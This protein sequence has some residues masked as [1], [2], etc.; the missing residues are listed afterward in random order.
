MCLAL[1]SWCSVVQV[2]ASTPEAAQGFWTIF[3]TRRA[4][5]DEGGFRSAA[6]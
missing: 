3:N 6:L 5:D 1:L 2:W 4:A